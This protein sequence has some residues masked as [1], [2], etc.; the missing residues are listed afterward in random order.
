MT[1][2]PQ[3][4]RT[5]AIRAR[6]VPVVILIASF[7]I[8]GPAIGQTYY[9]GLSGGYAQAVDTDVTLTGFPLS[10]AGFEAGGAAAAIFGFE[11]HDGWRLEGELSW[12]RTGLDTLDGA[13]VGGTFETWATMVNVFYRIDAG[14]SAALYLG[15]GAGAARVE[16]AGVVTANGPLDDFDLAPAWQAGAGVEFATFR[17]TTLSIDYRYLV[18]N[19]IDLVDDSGGR[20]G[21]DLRSNSAMIGL[22]FG[23]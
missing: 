6:I 15:A 11:S 3:T 20:V 2:F 19:R 13:T 21:V 17:R 5:A 7:A 16:A 12:R 23:F 1:S 4:A 18:V 10:E 14:A 8:S 9:V 22:R